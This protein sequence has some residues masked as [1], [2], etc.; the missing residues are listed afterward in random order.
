L[1]N[2]SAQP[3]SAHAASHNGGQGGG[4]GGGHGGGMPPTVRLAHEIALQF[5]HLPTDEAAVAIATHIKSFWDPRMRGQLRTQAA[6]GY[7]LAPSVSAA[8]ALLDQ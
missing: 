8:L 7:E 5:Q 4:Q 1:T 2:A 3:G 6:E